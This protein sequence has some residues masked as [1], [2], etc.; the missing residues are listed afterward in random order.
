MTE[1][2]DVWEAVSGL[3]E[4]VEADNYHEAEDY[5][6][7]ALAHIRKYKRTVSTDE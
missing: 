7:F 3:A 4:A 6:L 2:D 1:K 5:A